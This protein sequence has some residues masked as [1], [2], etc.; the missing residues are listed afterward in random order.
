MT[1]IRIE[2]G[3][4]VA[5]LTGAGISAESGIATFREA[6][7]LWERHSIEDVATP[8]GFAR[9]PLMVWRFYNQRR[10]DL[11][12]VEPNPA[13]LALAGMEERLGD[14]FF[15]ITQ[16]VDDLHERAGSKRI[17][18]MHGELMKVRCLSCSAVY[19]E[20]TDLPDVPSC[21]DCGGK[22][23]PHVVWFG[24]MPFDLE[25]IQEIL[26]ECS[27]FLSVGTSGLVYPAAQFIQMA[28]A[29]GAR[30]VC[31]NPDPEARSPFADHFICRKAGE[32]LPG[33]AAES[34]G[35]EGL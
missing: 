31:V 28:Q 19:A 24:E 9:D 18:H 32:A 20:E 21:R 34:L 29:Y 14:D 5:V 6:G 26:M 4:R 35:L 27:W 23:R 17:I 3:A 7:G 16:N 13:H 2:P 11:R 25:R 15:L 10:K 22:L 33:L 1:D 30:T 12:G 8:E